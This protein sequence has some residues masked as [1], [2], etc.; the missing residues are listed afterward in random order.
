MESIAR[1]SSSATEP[2]VAWLLFAMLVVVGLAHFYGRGMITNAVSTLF[3]VKERESI[4]TLASPDLRAQILLIIYKVAVLALSLQ[5]ICSV[6]GTFSFVSFLEI[7]AAVVVVGVVKYLAARL[8][9][10][11]FFDSKTF[12]LCLQHYTNLL[13][14]TT[15][16]AY[17]LLLVVVFCSANPQQ[18]A[19]ILAFILFSFYL[20]CLSIK[21]FR[22]FFTKI[23]ACFYILLYLCTLELLPAFVML[24]FT[25]WLLG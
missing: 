19:A 8:V 25:W 16:F 4:F 24:Q 13:T 22:L 17:P 1:I 9:A 11:V 12:G 5:L 7:A 21:L 3:S 15:L 20:L 23:F 2:W 6:G 18:L 10:Y 14:A